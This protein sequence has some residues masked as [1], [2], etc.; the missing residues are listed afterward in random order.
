MRKNRVL[1]IFIALACAL[2]LWIYVVT[3][4]TPED[5]I[6]ISDIPV[7]FV[8]ENE[9]RTESG[10]IISNRSVNT[11]TVKFHGNRALLRQLENDKANIA[12]TVDVSGYT[13]DK[14]TYSSSY[15]VVLPSALTDQNITVTDRSPRTIQFSV[16]ELKTRQVELRG[17]FNGTLANGFVAQEPVFDPNSISVTGPEEIV[18]RIDYAQVILDGTGVSE[19]I[20]RSVGYTL[21]D[22]DGAPIRTDDLIIAE[23]EVEVSMAVLREKSIPLTVSILPGGGASEENVSVTILPSEITLRGGRDALNAVD[24]LLL[25]E[26]PLADL[27][28]DTTMTFPIVL[29][30]NVTKASEDETATVAIQFSGLSKA[31]KVITQLQVINVADSLNYELGAESVSVLLRGTKEAIDEIDPAALTA[32]LDMEEYSDAGTYEVPVR[33]TLENDAVGVVGTS[34]VPVVLTALPEE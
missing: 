1:D 33:I 25:G 27:A 26:I 28:D 2:C 22:V 10:L 31:E 30:E 9:L 21:V 7:T 32:V 13:A 15:R 34:T 3:I 5:D 12:A 24:S 29:P 6:T 19:S 23:Q 18:D 16:V 4:V 8:G 14:E 20:K 17:I 11:V